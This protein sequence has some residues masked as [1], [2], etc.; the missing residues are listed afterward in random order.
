MELLKRVQDLESQRTSK[1][2]SYEDSLLAA[3][4]AYLYQRDPLEKAKRSQQR[5][6][7]QTNQGETKQ[8]GQGKVVMVKSPGRAI[9]FIKENGAIRKLSN[10]GEAQTPTKT[11]ATP[12]AVTMHREPRSVGRGPKSDANSE[13]S[14]QLLLSQGHVM[15]KKITQGRLGQIIEEAVKQ[16]WKKPVTTKPLKAMKSKREAIL[17]ATSH[18]VILRVGCQCTHI[19]AEGNRCTSRRWLEVHH[20]VEVSKGGT[21]D[22]SNLTT[23]CSAHHRHLHSYRRS[24][25]GGRTLSA[26]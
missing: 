18:K 7:K 24:L 26:F 16:L 1:A 8:T 21:N 6:A 5:Q 10:K 15:Q 20:I 3:M 17:A 23:L 25:P 11:R 9:N 4:K 13:I 2:A 14:T 19:D 12:K 22:L